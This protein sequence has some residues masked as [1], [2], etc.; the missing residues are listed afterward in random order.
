M[1]KKCLENLREKNPLIHNIT[2]Y[3]TAND[4]A[5]IV[6]ACGAS[7]IMADEELEVEEITSI[8]AGLCINMGTPSSSKIPSMLKAGK[9]ANLL[10][11]PIVLDPVGVGASEFRTEAAF[12]LL[13]KIR[14]SAVRG[15]ISEIK[16]LALGIKTDTPHKSRGV[17]ADSAD[18]LTTDNIASVIDFAKGFSAKTGAVTI[19]SGETDIV[20]NAE[21][22]YLIRNGV[23]MMSKIT[24][25]GCMLSALVASFITANP[26][27]P[28]EASAAAVCAMGICGEIA[29]ERLEKTGGGTSTFRNYLT[30]AVSTLDGSTLERR[31]IYERY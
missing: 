28:L 16:A 3:V 13:R 29:A 8:C 4:V 31:A 30:D 10:S 12:Q 9:K 18:R 11:H 21:E 22:A 24:G 1:F 25:S 14:F 15:N 17:D 23:P 26:D 27:N 2:N 20:C 19:I 6:L 5:N 7:P